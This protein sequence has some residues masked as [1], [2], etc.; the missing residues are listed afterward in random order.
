MRDVP[1]RGRVSRAFVIGLQVA[2]VLAIIAGIVME[3]MTGAGTAY[4]MVTSGSVVIVA[5]SLF[6]LGTLTRK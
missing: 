2:G 4:I 1:V 3:F 5:G 6:W